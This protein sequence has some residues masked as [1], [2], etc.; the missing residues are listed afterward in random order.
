MLDDQ[1]VTDFLVDQARVSEHV[2]A[3]ILLLV[4]K[5]VITAPEYASA[6]QDV[7]AARLLEVETGGTKPSDEP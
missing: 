4:Q 2:T 5:G 1:S 3:L 7:V 6:L